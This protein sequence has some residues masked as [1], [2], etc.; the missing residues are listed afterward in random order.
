MKN[1]SL[2]IISTTG[3][4]RRHPVYKAVGGAK[5]IMS[6]R[7]IYINNSK[8]YDEVTQVL[9]SKEAK[10]VT[11]IGYSNKIHVF[12]GPGGFPT[13]GHPTSLTP[14]LEVIAVISLLPLEGAQE[15]STT[16]LL[17][18]IP[19]LGFIS[20]SPKISDGPFPTISSFRA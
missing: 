2:L 20:T 18:G 12:G 10:P 15:V 8:F 11:C 14:N 5:S 6:Y 16:H 17:E 7:A 13:K 1:C 19:L 3:R 9:F 4:T